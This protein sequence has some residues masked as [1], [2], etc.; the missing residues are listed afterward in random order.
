[1]IIEDKV[2]IS[3]NESDIV[4]GYLELP[5]GIVEIGEG[6]CQ[7]H[8]FKSIKIPD[9][10]IKI[11]D[12]AF[13]GC[14][15]LTSIRLPNKLVEIGDYAFQWLKFSGMPE[16]VIPDSVTRIGLEAFGGC[17]FTSIKLSNNLVEIGDYAFAFNFLTEVVIPDSILIIGQGAFHNN[18]IS[19]SDN[20]VVSTKV[21]IRGKAYLTCND[22]FGQILI[23]EGEPEK[24][25]E[26]DITFIGGKNFSTSDGSFEEDRFVASQK[27]ELG[28][29]CFGAGYSDSEAYGELQ[30]MLKNS[31]I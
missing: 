19:K 2:L 23:D 14:R 1:M 22:E 20:S 12:S 4:N 24:W 8:K 6:A 3:I 31:M 18:T 30:D 15:S 21:F 29:E 25:V 28:E 27:N 5:E 7:D 26:G 10:V 11:G 13:D 16:L 17:G 9:S